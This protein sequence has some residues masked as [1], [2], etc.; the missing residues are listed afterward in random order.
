MLSSYTDGLPAVFLLKPH[1]SSSSGFV[2]G[3][4][5]FLKSVYLFK[6]IILKHT[7]YCSAV[8]RCKFKKCL[9]QNLSVSRTH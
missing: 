4:Y 1:V 3:F 6:T 7:I 5:L 9:R 2:A 8:K